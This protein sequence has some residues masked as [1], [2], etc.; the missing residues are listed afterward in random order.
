LI[1]REKNSRVKFPR[2]CQQM[3]A[4]NSTFLQ[5]PKKKIISLLANFLD[6]EK[7]GLLLLLI[8]TFII[9][10]FLLIKWGTGGRHKKTNIWIKCL[11]FLTT[12]N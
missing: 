5:H 3:N 2:L 4:I 12:Q 8:Q 7:A 1:A 10:T 6:S 11:Y 9:K